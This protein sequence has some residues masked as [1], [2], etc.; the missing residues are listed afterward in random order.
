MTSSARYLVSDDLQ[1]VDMYEFQ[2][3]AKGWIALAVGDF[4]GANG[5]AALPGQADAARAA[6]AAP[7]RTSSELLLADQPAPCG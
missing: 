2:R 5:S 4:G 3:V 7:R 1:Q 6:A